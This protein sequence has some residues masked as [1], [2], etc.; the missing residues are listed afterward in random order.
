[1]I[2]DGL[3]NAGDRVSARPQFPEVIEEG[4][5]GFIVENEKETRRAMRRLPE[6]DRRG[7]RSGFE[8]RFSGRRMAE[9]YVRY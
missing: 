9:D 7:V 2:E 6:L 5:T 1:M 8:Q 4:V 3:R